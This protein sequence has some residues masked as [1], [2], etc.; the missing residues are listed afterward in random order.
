M[1]T[2]KHIIGFQQ[3]S[4]TSDTFQA[5]DPQTG[6]L[7]PT[8]FAEGSAADII[9]VDPDAPWII[10]SDKMA[11][12]AGNTPFDKVPVQGRVR[13]LMKGGIFYSE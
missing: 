2:G 4:T 9:L 10:D 11:A 3:K 5:T 1:L 13:R 6:K 12:A 7:L 8:H